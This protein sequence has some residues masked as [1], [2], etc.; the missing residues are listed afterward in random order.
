[1]KQ[2]DFLKLLFQAKDDST[3]L[4][5]FAKYVDALSYEY[6]ISPD[7]KNRGQDVAMIQDAL[8]NF[9]YHLEALSKD[10]PESFEDD[11]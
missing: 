11:A 5:L 8:S 6:G 7:W 4:K 3:R 1:M 10:I 9:A 2:D